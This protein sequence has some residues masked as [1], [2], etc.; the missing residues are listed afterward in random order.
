VNLADVDWPDFGLADDV[1][2]ALDALVRAGRPAAIA[3][4]FAAGGGSPRGVGTQMLIGEE[5]ACGYLS[6]GCVEADVALH[7]EKVLTTGEPRRLIY[8]EG[9][10]P[11]VR[12][13]C[14]GRIEV[15]LER[16]GPDDPAAHALLKL[17]R[18]RRPALWL[19]DGTVR[20]C[21]AP[22]DG[23]AGLPAPLKAALALAEVGGVC[24]EAAPA[25]FRRFD[26]P[27]KLIVIGADPPALA[28]AAMGAQV[29]LQTTLIRPKGPTTPPPLAGVAYRREAPAEALRAT[30]LDPW[31]ALAVATHEA[32]L[33]CEALAEALPSTAG[34][35]GVL[36]SRRRLPE[37]LERL[38]A[39]GLTDADLHRLHAPIGL[40]LAGKSPWEIAASVIA[41]I[42]Q[43]R[44][45]A[46]AAQTWPAR[47]PAQRLHAVVLAAGA[48]RRYGAPKL[49]EPF[50]GGRVIDGALDAAFAAPAA[51]VTLVTGANCEDVAA[52]ARAFATRQPDGDRLRIV[53]AADHA[54]GLSASLKAGIAA[55]PADAEA[56]FLFLGDMPR[57]CKA[58][59]APLAEAVGQGAPGA[60]PTFE[61]RRGHPVLIARA[62][63][64]DL[65]ALEGDAGAAPLLK[66]L[67]A[68]L[69]LIPAPDDGV[70]YDI[71]APADLQRA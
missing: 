3:T 34:Y 69:A 59:L 33:D 20:A 49:L 4:L 60:A 22:G 42:V 63:F 39:L 52:A 56:A 36:G 47:D 66:T 71:D 25:L 6:G 23:G 24:G 35:V 12:L 5:E 8:G 43:A 30:G 44:R 16:V 67:G 21:L 57:V 18:A 40:P 26:P 53:H 32:E 61:G 65:M 54:R 31:T 62:L 11:D 28:M 50:K 64:A 58:V 51:T 9:G 55:L 17:W 41:E 29:G 37:R 46:E 45:T 15:L 70:L 10:P 2:P 7:A 38:R 27:G 19:T 14:G 48:A 68:A 1:R 13:P